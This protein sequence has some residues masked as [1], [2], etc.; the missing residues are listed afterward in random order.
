VV[1]LLDSLHAAL[2]SPQHQL[3]ASALQPNAHDP[4]G[5]HM[6][7]IA[8]PSTLL[9]QQLLELLLPAPLRVEDTADMQPCQHKQQQQ[10]ALELSEAQR[11]TAVALV[12][13]LVSGG[14]VSLQVVLLLLCV[15]PL[16]L[17]WQFGW[18]YVRSAGHLRLLLLLTQEL[19]GMTASS[20]PATAGSAAAAP[21]APAVKAAATVSP[22]AAGRPAPVALGSKE[23]DTSVGGAGGGAQHNSG[24]HAA[25]QACCCPLHCESLPVLEL[26]A[27]VPATEAAGTGQPAAAQQ[28]PQ[29]RQQQP[30]P[31]AAAGNIK[32]MLLGLCRAQQLLQEVAFAAYRPDYQGT[33][34]AAAILQALVAA[35]AAAGVSIGFVAA[36]DQD[37]PGP[38]TAAA[39]AATAF[40]LPEWQQLMW[41]QRVLLGQLIPAELLGVQDSDPT[42]DACRVPDSSSIHHTFSSSSSSGGVLATLLQP[43]GLQVLSASSTTAT[44]A[45]NMAALVLDCCRFAAVSTTCA[46]ALAQAVLALGSSPTAAARAAAARSAARREA[47][48]TVSIS[49]SCSLA[50]SIST[51]LATALS[52]SY[53][54]PQQLKQSTAIALG[55]FLP[56]ASSSEAARV[57]LRLVPTLLGLPGAAKQQQL[58]LQQDTAPSAV[59]LECWSATVQ[60]VCRAVK[61]FHLHGTCPSSPAQQPAGPGNAASVTAGA[62]AEAA[63]AA[64]A[65]GGVGR[66]SDAKQLA[67]EQ[68]FRHISLLLVTVMGA[69]P[70]T[71]CEVLQPEWTAGTGVAGVSSTSTNQH[72]GH[73]HAA[74][75]AGA[76]DQRN[77]AET[78]AAAA[79]AELRLMQLC[80]KE[81]CGLVAALSAQYDCSG[82]Q[83]VLLQLLMQL[84]SLVGQG[85]AVA[86]HSTAATWD[87]RVSSKAPTADPQHP[88]AAAAADGGLHAADA[89]GADVAVQVPPAGT[90]PAWEWVLLPDGTTGSRVLLEWVAAQLQQLP[91]QLQQLLGPGVVHVTEQHLSLVL[92]RALESG[93][94]DELE[95]IVTGSAQTWEV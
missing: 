28:H 46:E 71:N 26:A 52:G 43:A 12:L 95:R 68:C 56:W 21:A 54:S 61:L 5:V 69:L 4:L 70:S 91:P 6:Q 55:Q 20:A 83:A 51:A 24:L 53:S 59:S 77:P 29:R 64:A 85:Q 74:A 23:A 66:L 41:Q 7:P 60:V 3:Q 35:A 75:V 27:P 30:L 80:V 57:V 9:M 72:M 25:M 13:Q 19:L 86:V 67:A 82:V 22:T 32:A 40:T 94:L 17:L 8:R 31:V 10:Q 89:A 36:A 79:T 58:Q 50:V 87:S 34:Q 65:V 11:Q 44:P 15:Q 48:Q 2:Q 37:K 33:G 73:A 14:I 39:A 63:A 38:G 47:E 45:V 88:A 92:G 78:A 62:A 84:C 16:Q 93:E 90:R 1:R 76:G 49:S 81:L 18:Q 42:K